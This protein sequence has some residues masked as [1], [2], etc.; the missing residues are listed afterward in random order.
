MPHDGQ[1]TIGQVPRAQR[2]DLLLPRFRKANASAINRSLGGGHS[3]LRAA[4]NN[5]W[6]YWPAIC[7]PTSARLF[8][9]PYAGVGAS[10]FRQWPAGLPV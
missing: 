2:D 3:N 8:C 5:A 7:R 4:V 9:F 1:A 6:L 10:V